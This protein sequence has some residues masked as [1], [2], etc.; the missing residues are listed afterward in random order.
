MKMV[1]MITMMLMTTSGAFD[2]NMRCW[3]EVGADAD[4]DPDNNVTCWRH[5][6]SLLHHGDD[7]Q[8]L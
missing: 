7:D 1:L 4:A 8:V 5:P 2:E 6:T 3:R